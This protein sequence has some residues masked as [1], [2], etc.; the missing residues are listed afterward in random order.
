MARR[1]RRSSPRPGRSCAASSTGWPSAGLTAYVGTELEFIVFRD[2][3]E[4]AWQRGYRD[5]T[6]ANQYNVDYSL[7][8]TARVEPLLRRIRNEMAGA[9]PRTVESPRASATSASTR[10]PSATPR[11]CAPATTTSIYK[12][13]A[14]EIAAQEGMALTFMAKPNAARGQLLPHPLLAARHATAR[15]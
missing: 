14:K 2:T 9:G 1:Q 15:R 8:G 11:R 7:L 3:Y 6:P 10:S 12:N 4:Q 5:L 13:G